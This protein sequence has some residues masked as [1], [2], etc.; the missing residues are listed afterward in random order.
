MLFSDPNTLKKNKDFGISGIAFCVDRVPESARLFYGNSDFKVYEI[1]ALSKKPTPEEFKGDGHQSYVTGIALAHKHLV[2]GSYDGHLIWWDAASKE[3]VKS[4]AAHELWIRRVAASPDKKLIASVADD[5][6]C[7]LWDAESGKLLHTLQDHKKQTPDNYPSMLYAVA[8]SDDGQWLATGDKVGH[9]VVWE[10][11]TGKK[12]KELEAP[13]F[14]TWDPKQRRHSIGGIRS[15]AFSADSKLLSIGGIGKIGNIDHL[16]GPSRIEI[17]DWQAAKKL[18][19]I[20]DNK[21][22]GLVEQ[23]EFAADGSWILAAGGDHGGFV[24]FYNVATG[25]LIKQEKAPMHVHQFSTTEDQTRLFAVGH[26]KIAV[27]DFGSDKPRR[28]AAPPLP[29][30]V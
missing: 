17:H 24:S 12:I 19:T 3:Q 10:T 1:D 5:M 11:A 6:D 30:D 26:Q 16:G 14:Y 29:E 7:K 18:H 21:L 25:K 22:K 2:S 9:V 15:L 27:Y 4:V 28:P 8:F 23:M 13:G 20:E